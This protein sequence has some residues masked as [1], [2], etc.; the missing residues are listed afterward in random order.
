MARRWA[1]RDLTDCPGASAPL[2]RRLSR[3]TD[4]SVRDVIFTTLTALGDD[5]AV[6]GLVECLNSED[7]ALRNEA[8]EAMKQLPEKVAPIMRG[9][10]LNPDEDVRIFAVNILESLRHPDVES[11]LI[12]VIE[13]DPDLNVCGT[14]VDLLGEVGSEASRG[15]LARLKKRF[16]DQPYIQFAV[17]LALNRISP[18]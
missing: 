7:V 15:P 3:E 10:L 11:W 6:A 16:A 9:L 14:A 1:A 18:I 13:S 5:L 12:G 8:I 2:V 4:P 17:D